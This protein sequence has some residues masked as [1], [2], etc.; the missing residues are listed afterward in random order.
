MTVTVT[1]TMSVL[2]MS[3]SGTLTQIRGV[4]MQFRLNR[5]AMV[6]VWREILAGEVSIEDAEWLARGNLRIR[7]YACMSM[8]MYIHAYVLFISFFI[9][10]NHR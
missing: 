6:R 7:M 9:H 10:F 8:N 4:T 5:D 3:A 1:V 2:S